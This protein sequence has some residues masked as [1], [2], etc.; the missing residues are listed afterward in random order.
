MNLVLSLRNALL[1]LTVRAPAPSWTPAAWGH[2]HTAT[3][4]GQLRPTPSS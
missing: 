1:P 2:P 3:P 4:V